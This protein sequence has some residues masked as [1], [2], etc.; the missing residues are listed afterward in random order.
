MAQPVNTRPLEFTDFSGGITDYYLDGPLNKYQRADNLLITKYGRVGKLKTRDGSEIYD[1]DNPQIPAG[2]Q[3]IGTYIYAD[4]TLF[5]HS[6]RKLYHVVSGTFAT[7]QGPS[8]NDLFPEG[9]GT[10]TVV[11][12]GPWNN[13]VFVTN[14]DFS[15][16]QKIY[17]DGSGNWQLRTAGLPRP[18]ANPTIT[19]GAGANSYIYRLVYSYTYTVGTVEFVDRG[20]SREILVSSA[21]AP[22]STPIAFTDIPVLANSTVHN[23]DTASANLKL[24]I[25]RT[26]SAGQDFYLVG[27]IANGT[28]TFN[29]NVSDATLQTNEPIYTAGGVVEND[30][31]PLCKLV[32]CTESR[33]YY[34][35]VKLGAEIRE[36]RVLQS[37]DGD[38]DSV[39][40]T[41]FTDLDDSIVG[42]SS[43][44]GVPV[45]LCDSSVFRLEGSFDL[46]GNGAMIPQ[47]ISDTASCV[48]AQSVV[49]TFEGVFWAGKDGFY[50]TNGYAVL[51]INDDLDKTY[52]NLVAT[53]E[54]RRRIIGC[55]DPR[56]RRVYWAVQAGADATDC[57]SIFV[58]DLNWEIT[59][60][61]PFT[62]LSGGDSFAPTAITFI[63]SDLVRGDR[64][65]YTFLHREGL[66][67]DPR[68]D[69]AA[70]TSDWQ[71]Q[72]IVY[73]H[74]S[75]ATNFGTTFE[76]KFIPRVNVV[77]ENETNLSLQITSLDDDSRRVGSLKPI[78][79]RGNLVW[80]DADIYWGDP[81]VLWNYAGLID[82][83]RRFPTLRCQYKQLQLTN[84][85][86]AVISSDT[87]GTANID[88]GAKTV[89]L[90][91]TATYD[92]PD[93]AV[94]YVIAFEAD[95]YEREY[96]V[97]ARTD[98]V[99]TLN[100]TGST[101]E[102]LAGTRWV[103]RGKPK[104]EIL[105]LLSYTMHYAI[106]GKSQGA[107]QSNSTGEVG[108]SG[109]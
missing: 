40:A 87:L 12:W 109:Q 52:A 9:V 22:E 57:D 37:I 81:N 27:T 80:G 17:K 39:P 1:T 105:N 6:A 34:A 76:K 8:G 49:Q 47:K 48:S 11:S 10:T 63:G 86:V 67:T 98:D 16:I 106:F 100:D 30:P 91:D 101:L 38:L 79:S 108:A 88:A 95:G 42:L 2:A 58:C 46:F 78:R 31:P 66:Y 65:G 56:R 71:E 82:E 24:E 33:A 61:T 54:R 103:I 70:A 90:T 28:T 26:I 50:F 25:Y 64:R 84:A 43:V 97:L 36:N 83:W 23:Y 107:F 35:H 60:Q 89:T 94:D 14:S 96:P 4:E 29:D 72:T 18:A 92:W 104:G 19:P 51:K 45:V 7:L 32:H 21:V 5:Y 99:L 13:H 75:I 77:C 69:T 53:A 20:P 44:K 59:T 102:T 74:I 3:R 68:V 73:D 41:F 85:V 15:A 55:Y 62:T 93:K